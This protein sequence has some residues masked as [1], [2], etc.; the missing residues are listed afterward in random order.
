M[1]KVYWP[2]DTRQEK[3]K[4]PR[5]QSVA[6]SS[7]E[8]FLPFLYSSSDILFATVFYLFNPCIARAKYFLFATR[9]RMEENVQRDEVRL[10]RG[11]RTWKIPLLPDLLVRFYFPRILF[12]HHFY[13]AEFGVFVRA[14]R[15]FIY[16]EKEDEE[17]FPNVSSKVY[18]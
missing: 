12:F 7:Q 8:T 13:R 6:E 10:K 18:T 2:W 3:I 9:D 17:L 15:I 11:F 5:R 16:R 14:N 1:C 4:S